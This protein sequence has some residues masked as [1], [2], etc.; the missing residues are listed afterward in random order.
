VLWPFATKIHA[1]SNVGNWGMT[2]LVMLIASFVDP[3]PLAA[4]VE[5]RDDLN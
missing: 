5:N 3:D 2:G 4:E 1:Q